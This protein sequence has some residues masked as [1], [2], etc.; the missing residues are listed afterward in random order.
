M[1]NPQMLSSELSAQ[2]PPEVLAL[3]ET[4]QEENAT[5]KAD[6]T[7]LQ[8]LV[9]HLQKRMN[10]AAGEDS[11]NSSVYGRRSR[12]G[13]FVGQTSKRVLQIV[14]L[15]GLTLAGAALLAWTLKQMM[16]TLAQNL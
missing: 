14:L 9:T 15:L 11:D 10:A 1:S 12:Q 7:R 4:V 16:G 6:K 8:T 3:L 5:L 2:T 13:K